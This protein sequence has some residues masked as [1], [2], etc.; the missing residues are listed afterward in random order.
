MIT[1][2][3]LILDQLKKC[4]R[5]KLSLK[6]N[7]LQGG[8]MELASALKNSASCFD[9]LKCIQ[10]G[11]LMTLWLHLQER[12]TQLWSVLAFCEVKEQIVAW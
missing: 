9:F 6:F 3:T 7:G 10:S 11:Y 1:I 8:R 4:L 5:L 2:S 12:N